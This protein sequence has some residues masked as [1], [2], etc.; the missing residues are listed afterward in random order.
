MTQLLQNLVVAFVALP[1]LAGVLLPFFIWLLLLFTFIERTLRWQEAKTETVQG[2]SNTFLE[3]CFSGVRVIQT[4]A[5]SK[6]LLKHWDTTMLKH[7]ERLQQFPTLV[8]SIKIAWCQFA[9]CS[10]LATGYYYGTTLKEEG[11]LFGSIFNVSLISSTVWQSGGN[12]TT[13]GLQCMLAS[14]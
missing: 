5:M 3:Q 8:R 1:K 12:N 4:F 7:I 11:F 6:P 10:I 14:R 13:K 9:F 2:F